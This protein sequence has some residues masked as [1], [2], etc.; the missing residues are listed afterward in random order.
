MK[1]EYKKY[2]KQTRYKWGFCLSTPTRS[3]N[4]VAISKEEKELW[5][6][7]LAEVCNFGPDLRRPVEGICLL[8]I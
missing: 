6:K 3:Y 7:H 8:L 4:L 5:K 1:P 2:L